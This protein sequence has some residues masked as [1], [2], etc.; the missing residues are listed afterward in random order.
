MKRV[1]ASAAAAAVD[2][3]LLLG[4]IVA[5]GM[6]LWVIYDVHAA[7]KQFEIDA[8]YAFYQ[9]IEQATHALRKAAHRTAEEREAA[10]RTYRKAVVE[11]K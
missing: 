7:R 5:A 1:S 2:G 8:Q 11:G 9:S 4:D 3:P 6:L 10:H